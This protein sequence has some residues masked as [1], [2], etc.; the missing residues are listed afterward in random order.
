M[1]PVSPTTRKRQSSF[2]LV[3]ITFILVYAFS[4]SITGVREIGVQVTL[5]E[6]F[7]PA[8]LFYSSIFLGIRY[9]LDLWT[10]ANFFK[11]LNVEAQNIRDLNSGIEQC[12]NFLLFAKADIGPFSGSLLTNQRPLCLP[13]DL[14]NFRSSLASKICD[15]DVNE[16]NMLLRENRPWIEVACKKTIRKLK[17][18]RLVSHFGML[19]ILSILVFDIVLPVVLFIG[20][21]YI[22]FFQP[23]WLL[24]N[25]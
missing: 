21:L 6:E 15:A 18:E 14:S 2:Y 1:I 24:W 23:M 12:N 8:L 10:D 16:A 20:I 9:L 22:R 11:W 5:P 25:A 13:P 17:Y 4:V 7:A 3:G 19:N